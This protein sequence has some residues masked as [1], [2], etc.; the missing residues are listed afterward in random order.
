[1]NDYAGEMVLQ[2]NLKVL[3]LPTMLREYVA[4]SRAAIENNSSHVDFLRTLTTVEVQER[5]TKRIR[6]RISE[7]QFPALKTLDTFAMNKAPGLNSHIVRELAESKFIGL[8]ENVILIGK[9]GTGKTHF[10]TAIAIEACRRNYRVRFSTAC[11]LVTDLLEA[12]EDYRLKQLMER[13]KRFDLL[14]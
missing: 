2:D 9:S 4:C 7:A 14:V 12:R 5:A 8:A 1:M 10:A 13:L 3:R 11:K 6:Q